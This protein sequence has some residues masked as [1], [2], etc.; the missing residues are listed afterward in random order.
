MLGN[1]SKFSL[2]LMKNE[3]VIFQVCTYINCILF[4]ILGIAQIKARVREI[5][6]ANTVK[7]KLNS[8]HCHD[9]DKQLP[10]I[11]KILN[12]GKHLITFNF[13]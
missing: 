10:I 13:F 8:H 2:K 5:S 12:G 7:E 4:T 9:D 1:F 6:L 3:I 11:H